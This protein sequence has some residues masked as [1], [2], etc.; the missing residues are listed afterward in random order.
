[1]SSCYVHMIQLPVAQA[2][3]MTKSLLQV[4]C[5][6]ECPTNLNSILQLSTALKLAILHLGNL[7]D[8]N[9]I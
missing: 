4:P 7:L 9:V 5:I 3:D 2:Y 8:E 6:Q 1:M